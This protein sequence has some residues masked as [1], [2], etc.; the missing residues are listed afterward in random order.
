MA[1]G[2]LVKTAAKGAIKKKAKKKGAE[3]AKNITNKKEKDNSSS[4]VVRE[5]STSLVGPL[6]GGDTDSADSSANTPK[7]SRSRSPLDRINSSLKDIMK[8]LKKRRKLMLNKSRRMRV[9]ADKEKKGKREGLLE[10]KKTG[11]KMLK[12]VAAGAKGWWDKLQKFLLMTMLGALVIA[13]KENWEKIKEKIDKVVNFVKDLWK[14]ME[15]VLIPLFEGLKWVVKQWTEMGSELMGLS[16]DKPK[17]EKETDQLSQDLKELEKK[18]DWVTGKFKEAEEGVKDYENKTF[19][20]VANEAGLGSEVSP[21]S[22]EQPGKTKEQVEAEVGE[23]IT[24][25]DIET[26]LGEFKD[27]LEEVN[28]EPIKVDTSKMKK[29][30]S[31]A[32]PV[33]ETG[34]A[35]VHKGEVIIPAHVVKMAGGPMNIENMVNM[36]QSST[37]NI[38]Q[39]P[40]KIISIMQGMSKEF[41]PMG[42]QIPGMINEIIKESKLGTVSKKVTKEMVEKME[43]TLTVLK[44]QTEYEDPSASTV[45]IR[46]PTPS[47]QSVGG[48]GGGRTIAV[49]V[50]ESGKATLNRYI[51]A[52][53]QKALY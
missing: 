1:W 52:L 41:A 28:V 14:F 8:T 46:V 5:K 47:T 4:I 51:N 25:S 12:S 24:A 30:E 6:L 22:E 50:G 48:G 53:T 26:K 45:I 10:K 43:K 18:K 23:Q 40:L 21:D 42:E 37:T 31:G 11:N 36:M 19:D 9:Q 3:M 32:S 33:P 13:I 39:N 49:P 17:V 44:E 38:K 27:K 16:K 34:P 20:E 2:A 35:I 29:Y 15:P 7:K